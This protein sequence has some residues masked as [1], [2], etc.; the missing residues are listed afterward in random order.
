MSFRE[1]TPHIYPL[2]SW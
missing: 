2:F 1:Y